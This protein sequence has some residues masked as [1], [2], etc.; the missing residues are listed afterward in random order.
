MSAPR[1]IAVVGEALVDDF[2]DRAVVGGAPF[3]VARSVAAFGVPVLMV[4]RIADDDAGALVQR[5]FDRFGLSRAGLQIDDRHPTGRVIVERHGADHVFRILD[6]QAWDHLDA[7]QALR[8]LGGVDV[9]TLYCGTLAQRSP[10][11]A[12]AVQALLQAVAAPHY[13]DLNLREGQVDAELVA[14][15]L[16]E[17]DVAKVNEEELRLLVDWF[18]H[19]VMRDEAWGGAALNTAIEQLISHFALTRLIVTRGADGAACFDASGS[20]LHA[21]AG[22]P[23]PRWADTVG[24]GDSFSS[25]VLVGQWHGWPL[26]TT[27]QRANDFAAAICGIDGAVPSDLDF[28]ARWRRDWGLG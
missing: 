18:V 26:A 14:D 11:S 7:A 9:D 6:D 15:T 19:P 17:A 28:Y 3:N 4:T 20:A 5:E 23:P 8:A 2:G 21:P 25:I 12:A 13:V 22:A 10:D 24:A 1:T 27:L 16:L